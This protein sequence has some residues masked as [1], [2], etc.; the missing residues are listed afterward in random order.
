M[1]KNETNTPAS[2]N[3]GKQKEE[4]IVQVTPSKDFDLEA[5]I[6]NYSGHTKIARLIFIAERSK[7]HE[8][9]ALRLAVT[10]IKNTSNTSLYRRLMEKVGD[11]L[12]TGFTH[13]QAWEASTE[14]KAIQTKEK[15]E[16]DLSG[17]KANTLKDAIRSGH[18]ELGHFFSQRGDFNNA[19]R[20]YVKARDYCQTNQ[21][22]IDMCLNVIK[23][24]I[25]LGNFAHVLSYVAKAEQSGTWTQTKEGAEKAPVSASD[26]I[27]IA[28]LNAASGLANLDSRKYKQAA[29][30][31]LEV[32]P[33]LAN[34]FND[35]VA[36]IDIAVYGALCALATYD[37]SELK[38]KVLENSD[39]KNF[40]EL[41]PDIRDIINDFYNSK[42]GSCLEKLARFKNDLQLDLHLHDHIA[43]LYEKIR[44][45]AIVQYFSPFLSVDLNTMAAAFTTDLAG[46]EK[47]LSKLITEGVI[48]AR[49]DSHNK[50]LYAKQTD[51]RTVTFDKALKMGDNFQNNSRAMLLRA[52]LIRNDF[53]VKPKR[54]G[55]GGEKDKQE[56]RNK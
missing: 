31:F 49:I 14:K 9:D 47:E 25:E 28:K 34:H 40:T 29:K 17:A 53:F 16:L 43:A 19:L 12:G 27:V 13:D 42:Y 20:A 4:P 10:E 5:Y 48:S 32:S 15:L 46:L 22:V 7:K 6:S 2:N 45:K 37:R 55:G 11:K 33:D 35:V 39:F 44:N 26:R 21:H 30:K 41:I 23:A 50:R 54:D 56:R 24:S 18:D 1:S 8:V 51:E 52:N 38:K 36:P 3:E